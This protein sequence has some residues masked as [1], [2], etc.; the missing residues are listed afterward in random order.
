M[1]GHSCHLRYLSSGYSGREA[2]LRDSHDYEVLQ[3]LVQVAISGGGPLTGSRREVAQR[4]VEDYQIV[5]IEAVSM[6]EVSKGKEED[7]QE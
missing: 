7:D 6:N 4:A 5:V 1:G 3:L 2:S